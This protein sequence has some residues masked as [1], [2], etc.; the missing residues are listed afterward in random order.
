LL[1]TSDVLDVSTISTTVS[2]HTFV[3]SGDDAIAMT[4]AQQFCLVIRG[5]WAQNGVDYIVCQYKLPGATQ[6]GYTLGEALVYGVG[7][8]VDDQLYPTDNTLILLPSAHPGDFI[9]WDTDPFVADEEYQT[10][11]F[12]TLMRAYQN[13]AYVEGDPFLVNIS[14]FSGG[15]KNLR[16]FKGF[17][18]PDTPVVSNQITLEI[19]WNPPPISRVCFDGEIKTAIAFDGQHETAIAFDG[20]HETAM[21]F[22]GRRTPTKPEEPVRL[23]F[24][25]RH[26]TAVAFDGRHETAMAFDG[27]H[28]TA[29]LFD[30]RHETAIAFD[31]RHTTQLTKIGRKT[32]QLTFDG[33]HETSMTFVGRTARGGDECD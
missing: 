13:T 29:M 3:F 22:T 19:Q 6:G 16:V 24:D 9:F 15:Q 32:T 1:A 23:R 17:N 28:E 8:G 21:L 5:T 25:G 33:K 4:L 2:L 26:T 18:H 12:S 10:P 20:Q 30:G 14:R 7:I 27:R 31:G 11:D